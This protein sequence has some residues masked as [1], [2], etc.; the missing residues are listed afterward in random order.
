MVSVTYEGDDIA[1]I[2]DDKITVYD[3]DFIDTAKEIA[4]ELHLSIDRDYE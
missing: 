1:E 4:D 3:S 2:T